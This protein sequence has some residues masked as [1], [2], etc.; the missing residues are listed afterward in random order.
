MPRW[1]AAALLMLGLGCLLLGT[2][3][4]GQEMEIPAAPVPL[5]GAALC[6]RVTDESGKG[7]G[8]AQVVVYNMVVGTRAFPFQRVSS[9][10]GTR[11]R[12]RR[13][14]KAQSGG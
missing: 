4:Q 5:H 8:G 6:G 11:S 14:R 9:D 12:S 7:I 13:P 1:Q 2:L 10:T 3:A